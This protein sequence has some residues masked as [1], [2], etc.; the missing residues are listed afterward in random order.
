ML[1]PQGNTVVLPHG[2]TRRCAGDAVS[3]S[4]VPVG[5]PHRSL[6]VQLHLQCHLAYEISTCP[7]YLRRL[8][9]L[10]SPTPKQPCLDRESFPACASGVLRTP[11]HRRRMQGS[12]RLLNILKELPGVTTF[13][14]PDFATPVSVCRAGALRRRRLDALPD[15]CLT[16]TA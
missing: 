11:D 15:R 10:Y 8:G 12:G 9:L 2:F 14:P 4:D 1:P 6:M 3:S 7:I 16:T 5:S 13:Q